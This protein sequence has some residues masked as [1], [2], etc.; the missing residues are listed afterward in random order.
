MDWI[1]ENIFQKADELESELKM[2][3]WQ[4]LEKSCQEVLQASQQI[5]Q[6]CGRM[7]EASQQDLSLGAIITDMEQAN[8][9][10][11]RASGRVYE[12][13]KKLEI[14]CDSDG[15][16]DDDEDDGDDDDEE[17]D[18]YEGYSGNGVYEYNHYHNYF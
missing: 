4:D 5:K 2:K 12:L 9:Q 16:D 18:D 14:W 10:L 17:E 11:E 8:I 3:A 1:H 7:K 6:A 13:R 15:E